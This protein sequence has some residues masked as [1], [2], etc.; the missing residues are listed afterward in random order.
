VRSSLRIMTAHN[1][2][3]EQGTSAIDLPVSIGRVHE[4]DRPS[5]AASED[6][7]APAALAARGVAFALPDPGS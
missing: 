2:L 6:P 5:R 7:G 4:A 1:I 3:S